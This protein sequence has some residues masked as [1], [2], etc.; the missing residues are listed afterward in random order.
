MSIQPDEIKLYGSAV[1]PDDDSTTNI[2]GA[3]DLTKKVEFTDI[4]PQGT[5]EAVSSNSGDNQT[6]TI[7][8]RNPAGEIVSEAHALNGTTVVSFSTTFERILRAVLSAA[9][10]GTVTIRESGGGDDL[11][12]MEPGITEV[13]RPFYNASTPSSG[14]REYYEKVFFR[15]ESSEGLTLTNAVIKETSDPSGKIDFALE[16]TLDGNDTNG[17]GNNRQVAPSG[18]TFDSN[19]KNVANNQNHTA[20]ASQGVWLRLTLGS[21]DAAMKTTYTLSEEGTST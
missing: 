7:Y 18:Y 4:S 19:D 6:L 21:G 12:T 2:G 16:S 14:T 5:V 3:V 17:S 8:G 9:A 1:M 20:N 10:A 15:N 13:R 11:I